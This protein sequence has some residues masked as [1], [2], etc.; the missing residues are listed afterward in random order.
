MNIHIL[1]DGET[2][3]CTKVDSCDF[4]FT[5]DQHFETDEEALAWY[6]ESM[7]PS[8][9][10]YASVGT[11]GEWVINTIFCGTGLALF[12]GLD[13]NEDVVEA[14]MNDDG[15][16]IYRAANE[17]CYKVVTPSGVA[18]QSNAPFGGYKNLREAAFI[19]V[20][21]A[22]GFFYEANGVGE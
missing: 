16:I 10:Y 12:F 3:E 21:D 5:P 9:D 13:E 6:G 8:E 17:G 14:Y 18:M 2:E 4:A 11:Y 1:G 19:A 20:Q 7:E 15:Y 22:V